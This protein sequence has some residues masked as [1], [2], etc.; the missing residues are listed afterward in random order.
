[1]SIDLE[2]NNGQ[3]QNS[4]GIFNKSMRHWQGS[5]KYKNYRT[6]ILWN[7]QNHSQ[8]DPVHNNRLRKKMQ[9]PLNWTVPII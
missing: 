9:L 4:E 6:T 5:E 7:Y 8:T 3:Q 1:M 2:N